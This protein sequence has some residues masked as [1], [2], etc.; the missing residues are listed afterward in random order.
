MHISN[1]GAGTSSDI[2]CNACLLV[3]PTPFICALFMA[4]VLIQADLCVLSNWIVYDVPHIYVTSDSPSEQVIQQS[5]ILLSPKWQQQS[6]Q[7]L[8]LTSTTDARNSESS[9]NT[10]VPLK[11]DYTTLASILKFPKVTDHHYAAAVQLLVKHT[12]FVSYE[13]LAIYT[14]HINCYMIHKAIILSVL[15]QSLC[16]NHC[17]TATQ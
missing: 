17:G 15:H 5:M 2:H 4:H 8:L 3:Q 14:A 10:S 13:T 12:G 6:Q 9:D 1:T 16:A 7:Q 11:L